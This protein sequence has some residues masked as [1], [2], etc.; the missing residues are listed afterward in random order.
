MGTNSTSCKTWCITI[1]SALLLA[2]ADKGKPHL[3]WLALL[4][5]FL[6]W[7]LDVYYLALEKG[8]RRSYEEFTR[9][10]HMHA[11]TATDLYEVKPSGNSAKLQ[12]KAFKSPSTW[13]FYAVL[14]VLV[15]LAVLVVL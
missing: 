12:C 7:A 9:K 6:F 5:T 10:L 1:V 14:L 8:F 3:A 4:P 2:I 13:P 11:L 15:A